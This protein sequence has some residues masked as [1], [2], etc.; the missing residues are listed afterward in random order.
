MAVC[1]HCK[2]EIDGLVRMAKTESEVR[3]ED[4]QYVRDLGNNEPDIDFFCPECLD[5]IE[6]IGCDHQAEAFLRGEIHA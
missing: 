1:P 4:G 5:E 2:K 6:S 3:I